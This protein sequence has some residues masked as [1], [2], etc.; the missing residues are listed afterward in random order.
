MLVVEPNGTNRIIV[1]T[2]RT[3][4]VGEAEMKEFREV[5]TFMDLDGS[6]AIDD[7]EL[8]SLMTRLGVDI[9]EEEIHNILSEVLLL[10]VLLAAAL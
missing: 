10:G 3:R 2:L 9:S 8:H 5:F 4:K 1:I 7:E 6:G